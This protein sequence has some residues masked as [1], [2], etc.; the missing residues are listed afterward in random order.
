MPKPSLH[1]TQGGSLL[2]VELLR[3]HRRHA[4]VAR[5]VAEA[6]Q[7]GSAGNLEQFAVTADLPGLGQ[8]DVPRQGRLAGVGGSL[9]LFG[10]AQRLAGLRP[11]RRV[12][13]FL[14]NRR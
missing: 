12:S 2:F 13:D 8:G 11:G 9:Q 6:G 10:G 4:F 5:G 7:V 3:A 1:Q 14:C